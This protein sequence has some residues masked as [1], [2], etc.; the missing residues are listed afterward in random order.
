MSTKLDYLSAAPEVARWLHESGK[1]LARTELEPDLLVLI[2]LRA[3]QM[4]GCAFCIALHH[5]EGEAL[6]ESRDRLFG[7]SAWR[8]APWYSAR[9]RA[10]LEWTEALT[11]I[12]ER[13]PSEDLLARMQEHFNDREIVNLT[14]AVALINTWNRFNVGFGTSPENAETAFKMLHPQGTLAHA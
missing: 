11:C 8:E 14:A 6:G 13:H 2:T 3:S 5:R 12:A 9:E 7:L 1:V 4:N 10:A